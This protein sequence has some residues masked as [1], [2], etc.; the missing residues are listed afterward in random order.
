MQHTF[1]TDFEITKKD[2][3]Y[4][5]QFVKQETNSPYLE[6]A[7]KSVNKPSSQT[8]NSESSSSGSGFTN[9]FAKFSEDKKDSKELD[10]ETV[11]E[12]RYNEQLEDITKEDYEG[13][14]E[15]VI[16]TMDFVM[17]KV[18][19]MLKREPSKNNKLVDAKKDRLKIMV[20]RLMQKH[21]VKFSLEFLGTI[22]FVSYVN[23]RWSASKKI[24]QDDDLENTDNKSSIIRMKPNPTTVKNKSSVNGKN[25]VKKKAEEVKTEVKGGTKGG[26]INIAN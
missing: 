23:A 13:V 19:I 7:R 12:E 21:N 16:E 9:P 14:G 15:L 6:Q 26:L 24:E 4:L 2:F 17:D 8:S 22:L 1:I 10:I 20:G 11:S 3:S 25:E 18:F 5:T